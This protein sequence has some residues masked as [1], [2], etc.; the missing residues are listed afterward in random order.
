MGRLPLQAA[1]EERSPIVPEPSFSRSRIRPR[2]TARVVVLLT[3]GVAGV[4]AAILLKGMLAD[5][6]YARGPGPPPGQTAKPAS[7]ATQPVPPATGSR[8]TPPATS[9]GGPAV[10]L[11]RPAADAP[12]WAYMTPASPACRAPSDEPREAGAS[13]QVAAPG[14]TAGRTVPGEPRGAPAAGAAA[15]PPPAAQPAPVAQPA[16]AAQPPP[17]AQP[18]PPTQPPP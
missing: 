9:T 7:R 1:G 3:I 14:P 13:G 16:P 8:G 5:S 18:A 6:A 10:R 17:A 4:A 11:A 15:Q 12:C 2:L